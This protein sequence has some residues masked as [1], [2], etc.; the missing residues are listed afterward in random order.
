MGQK[1]LQKQEREV[2]QRPNTLVRP[3]REARRDSLAVA[4]QQGDVRALRK[5]IEDLEPVVGAIARRQR[6]QGVDHD[7]L[8]QAGWG[9]V[10]AAVEKW[11]RR[12]HFT[13]YAY[14]WIRGAMRRTIE[15]QGRTIRIPSYRAQKN[16]IEKKTRERLQHRLGRAPTDEEV[17]GVLRLDPHVVRSLLAERAAIASVDKMMTPADADNP[18]PT[19]AEMRYLT[20]PL[21]NPERYVTKWALQDQM[22]KAAQAEAV[23]LEDLYIVYLRYWR[24]RTRK[25][26]EKATGLTSSAIR[27]RERRV[28]DKL[29]KDGNLYDFWKF[30]WD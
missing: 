8:M 3:E 21:G 24:K 30:F 2:D 14:D 22:K 27:H 15:N 5:L 18:R 16:G 9:G 6:G 11:K 13:A 25:D 26:V 7:D 10:L 28:L 23:D 19:A 20:D 12:G 17:A 1:E 4:A 29:K